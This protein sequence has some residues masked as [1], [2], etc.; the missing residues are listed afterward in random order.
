MRRLL[1]IAATAA[2][3]AMI[4]AAPSAAL[5][6]GA[7]TAVAATPA[8]SSASPTAS[9][10]ATGTATPSTSPS[11]SATPTGTA[12]A[13]V[14]ATPTPSATKTKKPKPAPTPTKTKKKPPKKPKPKVKHPAG[15]T[16]VTG[17]HMYVP[18]TDN[19]H[20]KTASTVTV[21][22]VK[23]LVN[24]MVQVSWTGFTP[25][26]ELTYENT[27][28]DYPVMIAECKGTNPKSPDDCYDA[29]NGGEPAAFG[30]YGPGNTAYATTTAQGTGKADILLFT[31]VQNQFLGCDENTPC[32]LVVVP[33]Q[34]GDSLDFAKPACGNHSL[35][36]GG[37]DLGQYAFTEAKSAPETPNGYCSWSKRIVIP[38]SFSRTPSGCPLRAADI[39]AGGSPMLA[40][41]MQQWQAGFCFGS[42]PIEVQYNGS[43]N[44]S[45]AR[46]YFQSGVDDIAFTTQ[47]LTG[48]AKTKYTYAPVAITATDAGYWVDNTSTGQPFTN[49]RLDARLLVKMLTTSYSYTNDS[50]PNGGSSAFGCDNAVDNN[51]QNLYSDPEFKKLNGSSVSQNAAQPSGYE[52]PIVLSGNSDMTWETTSWIASDPDASGF[53]AG[54]FDP[55]GMHVNTYYLGLKYPI[56][57]FLPMDPYMPVSSQD[58]PVYPLTL[59]ANDMAL[60]Q[61]PG[62]Q[63]VKDPTTGNFDSLPPQIT[64]NRDLWSVI[65]NADATRFLIP[66]AALKNAAGKY[67]KPTAAS[68]AAAV[69]DMTV[70]PDGIT[71]SMNYTAKDPAAYPLT[72]IIYAIVPTSGISKVKAQAIATFLDDIATTGQTE[73]T[74]PGQLAPGYLPL[75]QALREQTLKAA[76]AVL[77]Q[78]GN[79]K[80]RPK[81][82]ASASPSASPSASSSA[83]PSASASPA[84]SSIVVSFSHP[85]ATGM[86]WVVLALLVG[87][88]VLLVTGPAALVL[89]SPGARAAIGA[90][91][92]RIGRI[93]TGRRGTG[94]VRVTFRKRNP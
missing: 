46:S 56:T 31:N 23:G 66:A 40:T 1:A 61:Q 62:T 19:S 71:R 30:K 76:D 44:E 14:T 3:M 21:S 34:G 22:Q 69:K 2:G 25:S 55:W 53:L 58:A 79:P 90:G 43:L 52:I 5:A 63:D 42:S 35:D 20:Y 54:Q 72:M 18:N 37:L 47:P 64:G 17:P 36:I 67:V 51:P 82:S 65:D 57:G 70:N 73:G 8:W 28:T 92:R 41:A 81:P 60:N 86:S 6:S 59:L 75:T 74:A 85:A 50:C 77:N 94:R 4:A 91:G 39:T 87:G 16:T 88:A 93:R 45:E 78:T 10:T 33:S 9:G 89:G 80:P 11:D 68:M 24:Q 13:T 84:A 26:S 48:T 7:K 83:S 38:L 29:T 15:S 49:I 27:Q 12:T 32:S